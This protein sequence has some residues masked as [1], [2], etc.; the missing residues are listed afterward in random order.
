MNSNAPCPTCGKL[1][2][3]DA[4]MGICPDCLFS[5]GF[6]TVTNEPE[7]EKLRAFQP[8]RPE[9][10][11]AHFP[12]LEILELLGRGGMGAVYKARQKR[13]DRMVALKILRSEERRV[14]KECRSR[15]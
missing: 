7:A 11:A 12:Q 5:A 9:E 2:P 14:G 1:L 3:A 13:L 8:P 4:P 10:L 6:G 15:W